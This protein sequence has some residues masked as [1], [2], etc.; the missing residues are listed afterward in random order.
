MEPWDPTVFYDYVHT[1]M[2]LGCWDDFSSQ[3]C[4]QAYRQLKPGGWFESTELDTTC[5]CDDGTMPEN[6]V[7]KALFDELSRISD[8]ISRAH[9]FAPHLRRIYEEQ[10]FEDVQERILRLPMTDWGRQG[11]LSAL[12]RCI[13]GMWEKNMLEGVSAF[14]MALFSRYRHLTQE[15]VEVDLVPVKRE[16]SNSRVHAYM[17]LHCVWGRKPGGVGS[18]TTEGSSSRHSRR[19]SRTSSPDSSADGEGRWRII[20][21]CMKG[22]SLHPPGLNRKRHKT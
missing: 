21:D 4:G 10:G 20:S 18:S 14:S 9:R 3:I 1:R 5:R 2:T 22:K 16:L 12:E 17:N 8:D 19:R 6:W 7:V 15:Q 11:N 13:G